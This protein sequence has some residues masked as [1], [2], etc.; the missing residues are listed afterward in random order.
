[1]MSGR[2][3][4]AQS[5]PK[6][7]DLLFPTLRAIKA[8]GGS[9]SNDEIL[10]KVS[11]LEG[12]PEEVLKVQHTDHR[13]SSLSYNLHWARTYLKIV[14]AI[15]N[16]QRGVWTITDKGK[17]LTEE[18]CKT[19]PSE[20]RKI[21]AKNKKERKKQDAAQNADADIEELTWREELISAVLKQSAAQFERL[22]QRIL[23][24]AGFTK[25]DVTGK[26]GD[27]GVDG[28]GILR[29]NLVS[30]TV[31]F[32]CKRYQGSVGAG[33]IRDFRGAM[34]G[35][36]DKGLVITTGI[37]SPDA[38]KEAT[39]DGAPAID[40]IDGDAL[41]DLLKDLKLGVSTKLVEEIEIDF[42]WFRG[43]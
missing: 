2:S 33:A 11:E 10:D 43:L 28:I 30:F 6:F 26:S 34:Q 13:Q 40:L 37:F 41:C 9:G 7:S 32:Q 16:N 29:V 4:S 24:E 15:Q 3:T 35:R 21:S 8:C 22:A 20:A 14:G 36:C 5:V 31:L 12:Y 39:R 38:R 19:V 23:R 42:E 18:Q 27:G 1:M 25:V 17:T